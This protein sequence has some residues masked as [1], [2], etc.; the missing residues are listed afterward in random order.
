MRNKSPLV[1]M[2][3]LVCY[4]NPTVAQN[5]VTADLVTGTANV[6]IPVYNIE[7]GDIS[8]PIAFYYRTSGIK[9]EDYDQ[10]QGL[11]WKLLNVD[12]GVTRI[13]RGFPDD[14]SYQANISYPSVKGWLQS[15]AADIPTKVENFSIAGGVASGNC[16]NEVSDYSYMNTNIPYNYDAEP[17]LFV[18]NAPGLNLKFVFD[19]TGTIRTIPFCDIR[20]TKT[21]DANGQIT[22]FT[23]VN[24]DGVQY[25]FDKMNA[26]QIQVDD[27]ILPSNLEAFS[28]DYLFYKRYSTSDSYIQFTAKWCLTSITDTKQCKVIYNYDYVSHGPAPVANQKIEI[29]KYNP[30]SNT[31]TK[32][33]LY[34]KT[35]TTAE[36]RLNNIASYTP[37]GQIRTPNDVDF[38][39]EG[40]YSESKLTGITLSKNGV[41]VTPQYSGKFSGNDNGNS[42]GRYFLMTLNFSGIGISPGTSYKFKYQDVDDVL[43]TSYCTF[44]GNDSITYGQDYWGYYNGAGGPSGNTNL[45]PPIW[46]YPDNPSVHMFK[47]NQIPSYSGNV[48]ALT[49]ASRDASSN[50]TVGT[51]TQITYPTG[52]TA[53]FTYDNQEYFDPDLVGYVSPATNN[54]VKGGGVRLR[55]IT[56]NDGITST[57]EVTYYD[58][59]DASGYTTGR[60]ISVPSFTFAIPNGT[61]Y[62]TLADKVKNSTYRALYNFSDENTTVIYGKVTARRTHGGKSLYEFN[63]AG[64]WGGTNDN[65]WYETMVYATRNYTSSPSPCNNIAPDFLKNDKNAYPMPA[66]PNY[67][68]QRGLVTKIT[69]Y[70]ESGNIVSEESYTYQRSHTISSST[71]PETIISA[72]KFD[73][74]DGGNVRRYAKYDVVSS[75]TNLLAQKVTKTYTTKVPYDNTAFTT[76]TE[77]YTY[78]TAGEH[79]MPIKVS[80]T[81]SD[82]N[83]FA[84]YFKYV[85]DYPGLSSGGDVYNDAIY[86]MQLA[87]KNARIETY[88]TVTVGTTEN[89]I[90]ANLIPYKQFYNFGSHLQMNLPCEA[91]KF[92][93][94]A[95]ISSTGFA[96]TISS[97]I[98]QKNSGYIKTET[99]E[100][101]DYGGFPNCV[102]GNSRVSNSSIVDDFNGK[103]G[104]K[105][106]EFVNARNT[107]VIYSSFDFNNVLNGS[108]D[109]TSGTLSQPGRKSK[110]CLSMTTATSA[111]KSVSNATTNTNI[112]FSCWI[113]DAASSGNLT[114]SL[115]FH[116]STFASYTIPFTSNSSWTYYEIKIP[117]PTSSIYVVTV[118]TSSALKIDDILFYPGNALA[119]TYSYDIY[120]SGSLNAIIQTAETAM[121][122]S[123]ISFEYDSYG[124]LNILRDGFNNILEL[125][126]YKHLNNW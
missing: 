16:A 28:R 120:T 59:D 2:I 26:C 52:G 42:W 35:Q 69:N 71:N 25:L 107:E 117:K 49:G 46:V 36:Q 9:V 41:T 104:L 75:V 97:G 40:T 114:V 125:R 95:G 118:T 51:L 86:N 53:T 109:V 122:G 14:I 92:A 7:I 23:I 108:M 19:K 87:N 60:A 124:R 6:I 47:L 57:N 93:S 79:R 80:K 121:G 99:I 12:P 101:Y 81:N 83:V 111:Y 106:A 17:D 115:S 50:V 67:D 31:Y 10:R 62:P 77:I 58:Y 43:H 20:I 85:K 98:F 24:D 78:P 119:R 123:T 102:T 91:W 33:V 84:S 72:L 15:G 126:T 63:T 94:Q 70:N 37:D 88:E 11:G 82:G 39:W 5:N 56:N 54:R 64:S 100:S 90:A 110:A 44:T 38:T 3:L 1:L 105:V 68:F 96:S 27:G 48:V 18:V 74:L 65:E 66:N 113:K 21:T 22:S 61:S 73:D 32:S 4:L 112:I 34:T 29:L 55:S 89:V 103:K 76:E 30:S 45:N 8:V 116:G 13:L